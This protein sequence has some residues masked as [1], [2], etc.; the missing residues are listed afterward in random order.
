MWFYCL[1]YSI[2]NLWLNN[3]PYTVRVYKLTQSTQQY[4][5]YNKLIIITGT[6]KILPCRHIDATFSKQNCFTLFSH[7]AKNNVFDSAFTH[8][9]S[10]LWDNRRAI[11]RIILVQSLLLSAWLAELYFTNVHS[12]QHRYGGVPKLL[13]LGTLRNPQVGR[14]RPTPSSPGALD[15]AVRVGSSVFRFGLPSAERARLRLLPLLWTAA[16]SRCLQFLLQAYSDFNRVSAIC[17]Y[18]FSPTLARDTTS[19]L[20]TE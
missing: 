7:L 10:L 12:S 17:H 6:L 9:A 19:N 1:M 15:P 20:S 14:R 18:S 3:T 11:F 13:L 5:S 8:F 16:Q 4:T 2:V